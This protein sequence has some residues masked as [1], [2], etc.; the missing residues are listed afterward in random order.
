MTE[1]NTIRGTIRRAKAEG[2][3]INE[4]QLRRWVAERAFPYQTS[5]NRVLIAW[6]VLLAF[7]ESR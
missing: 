1:I 7:L 3:G 5:G 6:S 4:H 2:L